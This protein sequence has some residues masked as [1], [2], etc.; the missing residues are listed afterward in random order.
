MLSSEFSVP[1][2]VSGTCLQA[3]FRYHINHA[4]L[5]AWETPIASLQ[6]VPAE[7]SSFITCHGDSFQAGL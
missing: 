7:A 6:L 3:K 5:D 2:N 4:Y 1:L